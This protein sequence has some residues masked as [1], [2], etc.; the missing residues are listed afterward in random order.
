MTATHPHGRSWF[1]S[2]LIDR[3]R[4]IAAGGYRGAVAVATEPRLEELLSWRMAVAGRLV[5]GA[6]DA[7]PAFREAG[8]QGTGLLIRL[9]ERD[10]LTQ[11]ALAR[12]QRVEAPTLCRMVDR[13]ERD[14][15]VERRRH[16]E[17]RRATCLYLTPT[18]RRAARLGRKAAA[19]VEHSLF[20]ILDDHEQEQLAGMLD[21]LLASLPTEAAR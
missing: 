13:L 17:D 9:L 15:L 20:G 11:I 16:P 7:H 21:R 3:L 18:G 19:D 6:A 14:G 4:T 1:V 2:S 8:A 10:G 12:L 5:R